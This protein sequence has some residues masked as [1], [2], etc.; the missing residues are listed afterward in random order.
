MMARNF[1]KMLKPSHNI[2]CITLHET[3]LNGAFKDAKIVVLRPYSFACLTWI[4]ISQQ[5]KGIEH[6]DQ[7]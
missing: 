2:T 1:N 7:R 5:A 6:H 3:E 4:S